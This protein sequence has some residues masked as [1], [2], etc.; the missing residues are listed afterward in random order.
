MDS[1][2]NDKLKLQ[3]DAQVVRQLGD[4]LITDPEQALLELVK[5]SYD[6]DSSWCNVVIDTGVS[7]HLHEILPTGIASKADGP[8]IHGKIVIS[9]NGSGMDLDAIRRGWLTISLSPK[10]AFKAAGKVTKVFN[11][12]PLGDKGLGRLGSMKLGDYLQITTYTDKKSKGLKVTINW[13]ECRSGTILSNV[14]VYFEEIES[15]NKAGTTIEILGLRDLAYWSGDTRLNEL[16]NKLSTLI[17]PFKAFDSFLIALTC[18]QR[19]IELLELPRSFLDTS[20]TQFEFTWDNEKFEITGRVKIGLFKSQQNAAL[21]EASIKSDDGDGLWAYFHEAGVLKGANL[22]RS[23]S[24]KWYLEFS[25]TILW[26]DLPRTGEQTYRNPGQFLG[27]LY[28][29]ELDID[30]AELPDI[31]SDISEYKRQVKQM[32]GVFI[33]R[34]QF[35]VRMGQDWLKLGEAWTSGG[36]YYGLKPGNTVGYVD[37]TSKG[38]PGLI[39]KSDREGF[40]DTPEWRGLELLSKRATKFA[41][42][43][44][45]ELRRSTNTFLNNQKTPT[46]ASFSAEE[47]AKDLSKLLAAA[48]TIAGQL[49][50]SAPKRVALLEKSKKA[51]EGVAKDSRLDHK[52][53]AEVEDTLNGV[54]E[55]TERISS[56]L[57]RAELVLGDIASKQE[58]GEL[59]VERFDQLNTQISEVYDTVAT[60]LAAQSLVHEVN[61]LIDEVNSHIHTIKNRLKKID[62]KDAVVHSELDTVKAI[63]TLISRRVSFINPML[64]TFREIKTE[65]SIRKFL[66][67]YLEHRKDRYE[68]LGISANIIPLDSDFTVMMNI[69]RLTQIIDNVVRNSE[70]WLIHGNPSASAIQRQITLELKKSSIVIWDS[71]PGIR[72]A[73]EESLFNIFTTDKPKGEGHGLGLFIVSQLLE[74]Q[75]GTITLSQERNARGNRYKFIIDLATV[76][77]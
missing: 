53:R 39:E 14:P 18:N 50:D 42:D 51:I 57:S 40:I 45:Q 35:R 36:S 68:S 64:R 31:S 16:R 44:L 38:N 1:F 65:I 17:S 56:E 23:K 8:R 27:E 60:G 75:G 46:I 41:A 49:K 25:E 10:R 77:K 7:Y 19:K 72:R 47:G 43:K 9:D 21:Y 73:M 32:A 2:L 55:L 62:I 22:K 34:D 37:I 11:R 13:D 33:Y 6:A 29:F 4:E 66:V 30:A 58:Y 59:I 67:D 28:G 74:S 12:T 5:N 26:D 61:P 15:V 24:K 69:G 48:K 76:A 71:G 70:Y 54:Q 52:L 63:N 3:I 20:T